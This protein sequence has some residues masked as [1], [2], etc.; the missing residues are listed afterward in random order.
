MRK[1]KTLV[2]AFAMLGCTVGAWA[3]TDMTSSVKTD[4]SSWNGSGT[5]G[6]ATLSTGTTT[7]M[8]ERYY[9][10]FACDEFPLKQTVS[11]ENGIYLATLYAHSNLAH[12]SS[13]LVDG[14]S[15]V[16]Y[17]YAK[18]GDNTSK[19]YIVANLATAIDVNNYKKYDV[20]VEVTDGSLELGLGLD[21]KSLS[22]WHTIQIYQL[23]KY[24][25][26]DQLTAP[27]KSPL[28]NALDEANSYYTNSTDNEAGTAK[29]AYKT[30]I[31]AAQKT[32]EDFDA[33]NTC[34]KVIAAKAN[35]ETAIANLKTAYQTF[36]L[37]GALPTDGYPFDLT[38]TLTNPTFDNNNADGWTYTPKAPGFETFGNAEYYQ[39]TFDISQTVTGLPEAYYKLK[40]KAFQ[41]PGWAADVVPAYV[42]A[43][44]K[45]DGTANVSAEIYVNSGS[46]KIKNIASPLLTAK[47]D[48]GR[49]SSVAVDGTTYY[50]PDNME[51]AGKYFAEGYYE[52]EIELVCTTGEA[53]MGFRCTETGTRYWTIFDD[54]RLYMTKPLDV[55]AYK[56]VYQNAIAEAKRAMSLYPNVSGKEKADLDA[57]LAADEPTT[58]EALNEATQKIE[59]AVAAYSAADDAYSALAAE[60][61]K[62]KALGAEE[63]TVTATTTKDDAI[64]AVKIVKVNEYNAVKNNYTYSVQL[65]EWTTSGPVGTLT[66]QHWDGTSTSSYCEQSADAYGQSSWDITYTQDVTLPAGDYVFKMTGRHASGSNTMELIVKD[67]ETTIGTVNDFPTGDTGLGVNKNGETSFDASDAAGFANDG[68]GRGWEWRYVPFTLTEAKTVTITIHAAA[69]AKKQWCS[70]CNYTVEAKP[71]F[72]DVTFDENK[73]YVPNEV[74]FAN[75]TF[76]RT[77]VEGWNG[78]VLPF[79]MTIEDAKTTFNASAVKSFSGIS[80]SDNGTTLK[81]EDATS[82]KAAVPFMIKIAAAP[83]SNTYTINKVFLPTTAVNTNAPSYTDGD[84]TYTIEGRY[85][86]TGDNEVDDGLLGINFTLIQGTHFYNYGESDGPKVKAYRAYFVNDSEQ[87][88]ESE[89]GAAGSKVCGFELDDDAV[90]TGITDVK[91]SVREQSDKMFDLQ[92]R[93]VTGTAKGIYIKN[94]KKVIVK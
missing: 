85:T 73:D 53:K 43:T 45:A 4:Q 6:T 55:A 63:Y 19:T 33:C 86:T 65:G 38:F 26:Y 12:I 89:S 14:Q 81:F 49:E 21:N 57:L 92:G 28:K 88:E 74:K 75:V 29:A 16:A 56:T 91:S 20:F 62:A 79:D 17:V 27:I 1:M 3:Q 7:P 93:V 11:V 84:V 90:V 40:V 94:G 71:T 76:N 37:S 10:S 18:S 87:G 59:A 46:Q 13:S 54:F 35:M 47:L 36:A 15:D 77:F 8:V 80:V 72:E 78:L 22:N 64:E 5:Y 31:D 82:I 41:R 60:N 48:K 52:N 30:V 69:T 32:Y 42:S 24:D 70:F 58:S 44:D 83:T 51:A 23:T 34:E 50:V 67:G 25:S 61:A 39:T 2:M 66:S 68:S 9:G